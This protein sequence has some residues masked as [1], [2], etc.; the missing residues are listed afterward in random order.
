M[1]LKDKRK[2]L[3]YVSIFLHFPHGPF[4]LMDRYERLRK[5]AKLKG[6]SREALLRLEW[7]IYY[8]T[9]AGQNAWLT[10][11]HFGV[12]PKTFYKWFDRFD[13]TNLAKLEDE[14]RAP[15]NTRK[16]EYTNLQ[17][18]RVVELRKQYIHYGKMKL[19]K[20]Y[21]A[22]YSEDDNISS[23]KIQCII[24]RAHIYYH[25][26]KQARI[27]RKRVLSQKR[28][29]ITMLKMRKVKGFLL[30]LDT[31]TIY[32]LGQKRYIITA[33]DK[34]T[35]V[36]FARMYKKH[37]SYNSRDFLYRLHYLLNGKIENIQTDNG[38]EFKKHFDQGC[39]KLGLEHYHSRVKTPKDN[40]DNERFA[41]SRKS[42][43]RWAI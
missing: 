1:L 11:R 34:W 7:I 23:W 26:K 35:K 5:A 28:K 18:L 41:L 32:W 39:R 36:A 15:K 22:K 37:S 42:L 19:L 33:I 14:S 21:E 10:C 17:Y 6:L 20:L 9:T 25:P 29:K 38:S 2:H 27:N 40:P 12:A 4:K 3:R 43:F 8:Y 13:E 24:E 16:K 30:C 31:V